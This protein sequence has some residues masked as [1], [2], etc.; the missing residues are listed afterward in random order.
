[1]RSANVISTITALKLCTEH[2]SKSFSFVSSTAAVEAEHYVTMADQIV[3]AG[4]RGIAE[5]D[6]LEGS[7]TTLTTGYGQS[8]WVAEKLIME[9]GKRGLSGWTVRPSYV[10]GD[11][12]TAGKSSIASL[13]NDPR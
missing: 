6:D 3:Q 1:M 12:K 2:H 11:S 13:Q 5:S 4:G 9:A 8:K 10:V 7:R